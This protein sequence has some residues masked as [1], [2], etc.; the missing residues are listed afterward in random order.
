MFLNV[1]SEQRCT[2][3]HRGLLHSAAALKDDVLIYSTLNQL[4]ETL[5]RLF[6]PRGVAAPAGLLSYQGLSG[7]AVVCFPKA[8]QHIQ[9]QLEI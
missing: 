1:K 3:A 2:P 4:S 5:S 9:L 7:R 6:L 8:I